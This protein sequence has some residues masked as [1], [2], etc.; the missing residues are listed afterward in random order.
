MASHHVAEDDEMK[1]F[2]ELTNIY[3][4]NSNST[5]YT[6]VIYSELKEF[7]SSLRVHA[8]VENQILFPKAISLE[9]NVFKFLSSMSK[10]N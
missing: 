10:K 2:I 8:N 1:G 4:I 6:K 9:Q 3:F 7:E 5:T